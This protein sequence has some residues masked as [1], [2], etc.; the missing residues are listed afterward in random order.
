V[1]VFGPER[2]LC[3]NPPGCRAGVE[4]PNAALNDLL[5]IHEAFT[6]WELAKVAA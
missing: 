1:T 2:G 3:Y 6:A 5:E 4:E